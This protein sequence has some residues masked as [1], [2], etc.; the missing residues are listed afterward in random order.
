MKGRLQGKVAIVTGAGSVPGV[1]IGNGK[2]T[3]VLYAR[4]GA[5][6][7]LVD[8]RIEAAEDTEKMIRG[9]G[10]ECFS[11]QADVTQANQCKSMVDECV[12]KYGRIDILHNNVGIVQKPPGDVIEAEEATWDRLMNVNLKSMFLTCRSVLPQMLQQR[13]GMILNVSSVSA[14]Y[15]MKAFI[16]TVT[17]AGV[18]ALTRCI[19]VEYADRG[20]R[21]NA[22]MP[23]IIDTPLFIDAFSDEGLEAKK[24]ERCEKIPMNQL[25]DAWDVAHASLFLVSDEAKYITGQLLGVDGGMLAKG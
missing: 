8:S 6:V 4:E 14:L 25:G 10:G 21:A 20:I 13:Y 16:Y 18:N 1:G 19:A 9:E 5:A 12:H 2:A 24:K 23:G 15:Y 7:I 17:K 3:A 11:Y 22:I